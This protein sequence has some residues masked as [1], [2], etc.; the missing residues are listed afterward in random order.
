MG[1]TPNPGRCVRI[2]WQFSETSRIISD[3]VGWGRGVGGG[4]F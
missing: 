1:V 4:S 3:G 2:R